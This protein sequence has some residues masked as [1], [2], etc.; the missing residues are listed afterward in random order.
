MPALLTAKIIP[1]QEHLFQHIPVPYL[2]SH[3][4]HAVGLAELGKAHVGHNGAHH[5]VFGQ[6]APGLHIHSADGHEEIPVH[7]VAVLVHCQTAVRIAVKGYAGVTV[8]LPD[9]FHQGLHVGGTAVIVDVHPVGLRVEDVTLGPQ[10]REQQ[11]GRPGSGT[12]GA[13][14]GNLHAVQGIEHRGFNMVHI[15]PHYIGGRQHLSHIP[16]GRTG[17]GQGLV[18]HNGFNAFF[19]GVGELVTVAAENLNA[20]ELAGVVG[21][22]NHNARIGFI[23]SH[24]KRHCRGGHH[25]QLHH[26]GPYAAQAGSQGALQHIAG[27]P[28]ILADEDFGVEAVFIRQHHCGGPANL[29]GQLTGEL[30]IGDSP[31]TV[32]T[33]KSSHNTQLHFFHFFAGACRSWHG[34][35]FL[36]F[37]YYAKVFSFTPGRIS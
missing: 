21:G 18:Q 8:V 12:V 4:I 29:H 27:K 16:A 36:L 10:L 17:R 31:D 7:Q 30:T 2:G 34:L 19:Q 20:V 33:E 14:N 32:R 37:Q 15:V 9:I 22:G 25:A 3:K 1:L 23:L 6:L 11:L 24:Q 5:G 13:V 26:I 35:I 28:G